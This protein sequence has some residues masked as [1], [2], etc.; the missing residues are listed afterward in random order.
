MNYKH[1]NYSSCICSMLALVSN[2]MIFT[3]HNKYYRYMNFIQFVLRVLSLSNQN[4]ILE[5]NYMVP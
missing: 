1:A 3:H 5:L 4:Q 2:Y